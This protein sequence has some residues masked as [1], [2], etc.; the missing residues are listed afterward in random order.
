MDVLET[1]DVWGAECSRA[2]V[3]IAKRTHMRIEKVKD[4]T[5]RIERAQN[6]VKSVGG[7]FKSFTISLESAALF[8]LFR[9]SMM[10]K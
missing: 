3:M 1:A 8:Q 4:S 6:A 7:E 9:R 2:M 10:K 5:Q